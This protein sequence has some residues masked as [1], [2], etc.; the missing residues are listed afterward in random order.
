MAGYVY[1]INIYPAIANDI[2]KFGRSK[3]FMKRFSQYHKESKPTIELVLWHENNQTF[4]TEILRQFR[5]V[6]KERRDIGNEYF[7]GDVERM[8]QLVIN[9]YIP[10]IVNTNLNNMLSVLV[11]RQN[12][13]DAK[14][15]V[16]DD[17]C[18]MFNY[19]VI[20]DD[21]ITYLN[22][23]DV[24]YSQ[25]RVML[26]KL[27][28]RIDNLQDKI[29]NLDNTDALNELEEK[30]DNLQD[31]M[32][33]YIN[34]IEQD[35]INNVVKFIVYDYD[36][37]PKQLVE[38]TLSMYMGFIEALCASNPNTTITHQIYDYITIELDK[39]KSFFEFLH[40]KH[41]MDIVEVTCF[42]EYVD[43][44]EQE[45][46]VSKAKISVICNK[47]TT[48]C[49]MWRA[50]VDIERTSFREFKVVL[51]AVKDIG[52]FADTQWHLCNRKIIINKY[53]AC[54][55]CLDDVPS[56]L[57]G[58]IETV[59]EMTNPYHEPIQSYVIDRC[60][61]IHR[62]DVPTTFVTPET[63]VQEAINFHKH[64]NLSNTDLTE[65]VQEMLSTMQ[66]ILSEDFR[67]GKLDFE[68]AN[69]WFLSAIS[70]KTIRKDALHKILFT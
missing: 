51:D 6:F 10:S 43:I 21:I 26:N 38:S 17:M 29:E 56:L 8:K 33:D 58:I 55:N 61:S 64:H 41:F 65:T 2:Y 23:S 39:F 44:S 18:N 12:A 13:T 49:D 15:Q 40:D 54:K 48:I 31:D 1:L 34:S 19:D 50:K 32:G 46:K 11:K 25:I 53:F 63:L 5:G 22:T 30:I 7:Q 66:Y 14:V 36:N 37:R 4:E 20:R 28:D 42:D 45:V 69:T 60:K 70:P 52:Y 27:E 62:H 3:D 68:E 59:Q 35:I 24:V 16:L 9:H 57:D 47:L 67:K